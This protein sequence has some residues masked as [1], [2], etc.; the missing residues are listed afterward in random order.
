MGTIGSKPFCRNSQKKMFCLIYSSICKTFDDESVWKRDFALL[1]ML[2]FCD[3][4]DLRDKVFVSEFYELFIV[5]E[6]NEHFGHV[7]LLIIKNLDLFVMF[8]F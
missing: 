8:L 5:D 7:L 2:L 3:F 4:C 6:V 1:T